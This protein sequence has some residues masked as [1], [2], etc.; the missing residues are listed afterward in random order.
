M[1]WVMKT[2]GLEMEMHE[3]LS[4]KVMVNY[5]YSSDFFKQPNPEVLAALKSL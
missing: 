4:T 5:I 2:L 3:E 1:R